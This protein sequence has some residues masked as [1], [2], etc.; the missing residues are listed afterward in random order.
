[1]KH[2]SKFKRDWINAVMKR[3]KIDREEAERFWDQQGFK[4]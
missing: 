2:W 4:I 1:M 3:F